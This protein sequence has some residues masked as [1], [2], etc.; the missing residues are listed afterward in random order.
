MG[1]HKFVRRGSNR[2]AGGD[3]RSGTFPLMSRFQTKVV[4]K[5]LIA[6]ANLH[7][8]VSFFLTKEN[9]FLPVLRNDD[10]LKA[11][12]GKVRS[13][14]SPNGSEQDPKYQVRRVNWLKTIKFLNNDKK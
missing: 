10:A 11:E 6:K 14:P 7:T 4:I 9:M 2:F 3:P 1:L 5:A 13:Q 12:S 8:S